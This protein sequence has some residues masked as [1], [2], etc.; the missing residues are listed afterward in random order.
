LRPPSN[1][2]PAGDRVGKRILEAVAGGRRNQAMPP[3]S[4]L[5]LVALLI[6]HS[7]EEEILRIGPTR[8]TE[9]AV[10]PQ[11][12]MDPNEDGPGSIAIGK[13]LRTR[14]SRLTG[15]VRTWMPISHDLLYQ[16]TSI[17]LVLIS[18][19]IEE[20]SKLAFVNTPNDR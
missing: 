7:F 6:D 1:A 3:T 14:A 8:R 13:E 18:A 20:T 19:S 9:C 17:D 11:V 2:K 16:V 12:A 5:T 4:H 15:L 10:C